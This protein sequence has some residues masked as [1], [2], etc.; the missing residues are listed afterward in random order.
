MPCSPAS[1][2]K[3]TGGVLADT[4]AHPQGQ[5][6]TDPAGTVGAAG[7][8]VDL[9]DQPGRPLPAQSGRGHR[10]APVSVIA[11]VADSQFPAAPAGRQAFGCQLGD[12][13][14]NPFGCASPREQ[15][16]RAADDLQLRLKLTDPAAGRGQPGPLL[17]RQPGPLTPG[18][19]GPGGPSYA[20]S[21]G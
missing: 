4:D 14:V 7:P 11:R 10:A 18:R 5:L 6:G 17:R 3:I 19:P 9:A 15:H 13:R 20:G 21:P 8:G 2:I 12:Y 16:R 1:R